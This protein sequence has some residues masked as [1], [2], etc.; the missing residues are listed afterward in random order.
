M[1]YRLAA[2]HLL[3]DWWPGEDRSHQGHDLFLMTT[4]CPLLSSW[5]TCPL[6]CLAQALTPLCLLCSSP[7]PSSGPCC[8]CPPTAHGTDAS[9][10][11][12]PPAASAGPA[13]GRRRA[14]I[15][16]RRCRRRCLL[17]LLFLFLLLFLCLLLDLA[18]PSLLWGR[19][20]AT[21]TACQ[22][23]PWDPTAHP[24]PAHPAHS[25]GK[26]SWRNTLP[27]A[28]DHRSRECAGG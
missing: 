9:S 13:P 28:E 6:T 27:P 19:R 21:I 23:A 1:G 12:A 3:Q 11:A 16:C 20:P 5:E 14:A 15:Q 17:H 18:A 10:A 22:P 24:V 25:T 7:C 4:S 8:P 26:G 2:S